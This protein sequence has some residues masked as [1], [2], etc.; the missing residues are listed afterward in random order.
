MSCLGCCRSSGRPGSAVEEDGER[1]RLHRRGNNVANEI[2]DQREQHLQSRRSASRETPLFLEKEGVTNTLLVHNWDFAC[3]YFQD[4]PSSST[5]GSADTR[6]ST[7]MESASWS[8]CVCRT[9]A[10]SLKVPIPSSWIGFQTKAGLGT[11]FPC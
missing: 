11:F 3:V 4:A 8:V 2:R 1:V 10:M 5:T 9:V 6:L 7:K